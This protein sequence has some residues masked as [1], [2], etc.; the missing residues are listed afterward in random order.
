MLLQRLIPLAFKQRDFLT[1]DISRRSAM[2]GGLWRMAALSRCRLT[3]LRF[4][5]FAAYFVAPSDCRPRGSA[6][7]IVLI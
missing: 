4:C 6:Q 7:V 2:T 1:Q 3:A 5:C